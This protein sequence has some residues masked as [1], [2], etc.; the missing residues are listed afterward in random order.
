MLEGPGLREAVILITRQLLTTPY[1]LRKF[2]H[3]QERFVNLW[4]IVD[5]C[6]RF[7]G[8]ITRNEGFISQVGL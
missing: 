8:I 6:I 7:L 1:L 2:T 5:Y 3:E 4:I